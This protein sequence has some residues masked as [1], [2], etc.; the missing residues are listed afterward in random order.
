PR[1]LLILSPDTKIPPEEAKRLFEA[2]TEKNNFCIIAGDGSSLA[3]LE[4]AVRRLWAIAKLDKQLPPNHPQKAEL[5]EKREEAEL[6]F[7][8][9]AIA[10]FNRLYFPMKDGLKSAK[11]S[12]SFHNNAWEGEAQIERSL[13]DT[14]ASKLVLDVAGQTEM[15]IQ[16]AEDQLWPQGQHR[17]RWA[18]VLDRSKTNARW[19]WLPPKGLEQ[20]RRS[21][22]GLGRWIYT[23]A[24]STR[25]RP[26]P[27]PPWWSPK[28]STTIR[29]VP[30]PSR[31][32]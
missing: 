31:L 13:S 2:V 12:V 11:F 5:E 26:R 27:R 23:E 29:A 32:P 22:E 30:P 21:A 6:D 7:R 9:T 25:T 1:V 18:D 17:V 19:L 28:P 8:S 10:T 24:T 16:R 20:L 15:L 14:A 3:S 4:S